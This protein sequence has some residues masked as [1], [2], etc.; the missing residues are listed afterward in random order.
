MRLFATR[1]FGFDTDLWPVVTFGQEGNRDKLIKDSGPGD[2][3]VFV[4]T[5][6]APTPEL[7]R[8]RIL[9]MAEFSRTPINT[10]DVVSREALQPH[11]FDEWNQ[12]RW[13]NALAMLRAWRFEPRPLLLEVLSKQLPYEATPRAVLLSDDDTRAIIALPCV[14]IDLPDNAVIRD[15]RKLASALSSSKP[16]TGPLPTSWSGATGVDAE[17]PAFTYACQ[18]GKN[19]I[20][21]VGIAFNPTKRVRILNRHIPEEIVPFRWQL[22]MDQRWASMKAAYEM[23]QAVLES[24]RKYRTEGEM[25]N[26]STKELEAA[27]VGSIGLRAN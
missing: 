25:L 4:G 9:G 5:K 12:L 18:F 27:W 7:L 3:V 14:E 20:W 17:Q 13:P 15:A 23:E 8:G 6:D 22:R 10:L 2:R 16:T 21:K 19:S 11:D 1:A 26:C 24:L